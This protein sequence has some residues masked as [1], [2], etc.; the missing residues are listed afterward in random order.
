MVIDSLISRCTF[1]YCYIAVLL[2]S[3]LIIDGMGTTDE[4]H[5]HNTKSIEALLFPS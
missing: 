3:G 4:W 5:A 2:H 1:W